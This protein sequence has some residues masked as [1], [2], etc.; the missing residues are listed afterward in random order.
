[1]TAYVDSSA[2][3]KRYLHEADWQLAEAALASDPVLASSWITSVEVRRNLAR[4][5]EGR[6]LSAARRQA[7]RDF[8]RIAMISFDGSVAALASDIA[9]QFGV[10]ALD[11]VHLASAKRLLID[12]LAFITFDLRQ[13][14]AAR[15]LG[16]R[17]L[18]C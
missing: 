8:D 2:L 17:V 10:R 11:A 12:D 5:L 1:V 18:G 16:L 6:Q 14:E 13:G 7:E 4:L 15:R 3:L 9:E